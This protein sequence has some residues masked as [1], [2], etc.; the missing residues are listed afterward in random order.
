MTDARCEPTERLRGV[1]GWHWVRYTLHPDPD[2]CKPEIAEWIA[3]PMGSTHWWLDGQDAGQMYGYI[4]LAPVPSPE[5][6]ARLVEA[7]R[8]MVSRSHG[9]SYAAGMHEGRTMG[10]DFDALAV[11]LAPFPEDK[12]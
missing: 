12:P 2:R 6:V 9:R 1:D 10:S 11:A 7:A 5:A 4:Y 3:A 8:R